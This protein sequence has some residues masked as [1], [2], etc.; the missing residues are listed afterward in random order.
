MKILRVDVPQP[1]DIHPKLTVCAGWA[2]D[3]DHLPLPDALGDVPEHLKRAKG[4][5]QMLY[6]QDGPAGY[7]LTGCVHFSSASF[8]KDPGPG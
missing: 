1:V 5:A 2:D 4:F 8:Q 6:P 3:A 7:A